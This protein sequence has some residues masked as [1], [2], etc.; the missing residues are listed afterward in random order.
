MAEISTGPSLTFVPR[1]LCIPPEILG[2]IAQLA[3][4]L[5][6]SPLTFSHVCRSWRIST[7][8]RKELWNNIAIDWLMGSKILALFLYRS[9]GQHINI[10]FPKYFEPTLR[11]LK[12]VILPYS[13]GVTSIELQVGPFEDP[14]NISM[15]LANI[16]LPFLRRL[17]VRLETW[18]YSDYNRWTGS[19]ANIRRPRLLQSLFELLGRSKEMNLH[20]GVSG[21]PLTISD[22]FASHPICDR[23]T[24]LTLDINMITES[25]GIRLSEAAHFDMRSP[26][27]SSFPALNRLILK[28]FLPFLDIIE[29]PA[30]ID[31]KFEY[32]HHGKLW[33]CGIFHP[34]WI[35]SQTKRLHLEEIT[36]DLRSDSFKF[37]NLRW[38]CL[39]HITMVN[40]IKSPLLL[41]NLHTFIW[42]LDKDFPVTEEYFG[43]VLSADG[44]F[45]P[46]SSLHTLE[47]HSFPLKN[48]DPHITQIPYQILLHEHLKCLH[49]ED[50]DIQTDFLEGLLGTHDVGQSFLRE[51]HELEELSFIRCDLGVPIR[52]IKS[53]LSSSASR[54]T[55]NYV[56]RV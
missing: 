3:L 25:N 42:K 56:S 16:T 28:G 19:R 44:I 11:R 13:S 17:M 10:E 55:L 34:G 36:L 14:G 51:F 32:K 41:P 50:C 31:A 8:G 43:E 39:D 29:T 49:M 52:D 47:L 27:H 20:L 22:A 2:E 53:C 38:L 23:I 1:V 48:G 40:P 54:M 45:G 33:S 46:M 7:I 6:V 24:A 4:E 35:N 18:C 15:I 26:T 30:L 12:P 21:G 9:E 5:G 37:T